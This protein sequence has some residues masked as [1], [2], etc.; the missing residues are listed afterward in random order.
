MEK[1]LDFIFK[2]CRMICGSIHAKT[3]ACV[4]VPDRPLTPEFD[5]PA[6]PFEDWR[7]RLW[8]GMAPVIST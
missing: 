7:N 1:S 8:S 6:P 2:E 5:P 4:T 3:S